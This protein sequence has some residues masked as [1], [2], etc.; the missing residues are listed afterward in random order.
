MQQRRYYVLF[1]GNSFYVIHFPNIFVAEPRRLAGPIYG[2]WGA[3][4]QG[5][6]IQLPV[7]VIN[8]N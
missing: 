3:L 6:G 4:S 8:I 2:F 1:S 5:L 7:N